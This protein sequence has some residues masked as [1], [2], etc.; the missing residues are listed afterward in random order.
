MKFAPLASLIVAGTVLFATVA[1]AETYAVDTDAR[2]VNIAFE[3]KMDIEDIFGTTRTASGSIELNG[4]NGKFAVSIPVD[5]LRT[6]IELR[7]THLRS[8]QWLDAAKFP[9]IT[10]SGSKLV[11]KSAERYDVTGSFS[12]HGKAAQLTV[13]VDV[14][15]IPSAT[16]TKLGLAA[17]NWMRIRSTFTVKLSD[18]GI[19]IPSKI[20]GKVNDTWTVR[21]SLFAKEVK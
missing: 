4:D 11:K 2:H 6:G 8:S 10:F 3:S 20:A 17:G 15:R 12:L 21:V 19:A 5:S 13:P 1:R 18:H 16:A 9:T 14:K 7:D